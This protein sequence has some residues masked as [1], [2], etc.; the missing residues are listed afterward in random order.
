MLFRSLA[1]WLRRA[2][3]GCAG[4]LAVLVDCMSW[5]ELGWL[6]ELAQLGGLPAKR[7]VRL[8]AGQQGRLGD[9]QVRVRR[10]MF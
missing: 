6:T 3:L 2:G 4:L 9:W 10:K 7:L 8:E 1:S 5:A